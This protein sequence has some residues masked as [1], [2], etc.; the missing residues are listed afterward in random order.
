MAWLL[1]IIIMLRCLF[2]GVDLV[3]VIVINLFCWL[4]VD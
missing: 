2:D 3:M 4:V 1:L